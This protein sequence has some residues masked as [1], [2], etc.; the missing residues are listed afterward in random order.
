MQS[1]IAIVSPDKLRRHLLLLVCV[2]TREIIVSTLCS[3]VS[4]YIYL[5]FVLVRGWGSGRPLIRPTETPE[6]KL[7]IIKNKNNHVKS[8][9]QVA[10]AAFL[11]L[12]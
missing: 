8:A 11:L 7:I 12:F 3:Y 9:C 6:Q 10:A 4:N 5:L 1:F 2:E